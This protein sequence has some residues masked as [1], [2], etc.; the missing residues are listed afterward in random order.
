MS[1]LRTFSQICKNV[2]DEPMKQMPMQ[3]V[4][5]DLFTMRPKEQTSPNLR[6]TQGQNPNKQPE[7]EK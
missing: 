1:S 2:S 5:P 7:H 3:P 6:Q 4:S